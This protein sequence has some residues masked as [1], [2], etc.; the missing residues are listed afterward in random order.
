MGQNTKHKK[1]M[2]GDALITIALLLIIYI[3]F[4]YAQDFFEEDKEK[5]EFKEIKNEI[6]VIQDENN[7]TCMNDVC[8]GF[9]VFIQWIFIKVYQ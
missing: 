7:K 4:H 1:G 9:D 5:K 8:K 3:L 2:L 6:Q